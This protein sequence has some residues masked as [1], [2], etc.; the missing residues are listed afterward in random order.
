MTHETGMIFE[1][2]TTIASC[3]F[4]GEQNAHT[5]DGFSMGEE[6]KCWVVI[7]DS[8]QAQGPYCMSASHA[9]EV[10]NKANEPKGEAKP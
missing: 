2:T 4:C 6:E 10:W 5:D 3:P 8:C 9:I 1:D 7:C